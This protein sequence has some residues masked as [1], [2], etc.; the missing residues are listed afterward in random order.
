MTP[1]ERAGVVVNPSLVIPGSE[2]VVRATRAG[3]AGGQHVNK[4]AT[5]IELVWN[6]R[7]SSAVSE[8]QRERLIAKLASRIT[9]GGELRIVSSEM[10]SQHRN[11]ERAE[12]RLAETVRA[13]LVVPKKRKRTRPTKASREAR[14]AEK[15]RNAERKGNRRG[16][17]DD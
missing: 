2:L 14:L 4:T 10:R 6:I 5:R 11:R 8:E 17:T 16:V 12:A 3:G 13:A 1:P 15:H 7:E 9:T